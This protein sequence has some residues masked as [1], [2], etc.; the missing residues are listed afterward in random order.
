MTGGSA[1]IDAS[2][3]HAL[4]FTGKA[5]VTIPAGSSIISNAFNLSTAVGQ[6][7]TVSLY[8]AKGQTGNNTTAQDKSHASTSLGPGDQTSEA[9]IRNGNS[10]PHW[11]Y[12]TEIQGQE[13][14]SA[15]S[16]ICVGDGI[17]DGTGSDMNGNNRWTDDLFRRMQ[18][19]LATK[20]VVVLNAGIGDN[21]LVTQAALLGLCP[22]TD[23]QHTCVEICLVLRQHATT[24]C[25][26]LN[27]HKYTS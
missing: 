2:S 1:D 7:L 14:S 19:N 13:P 22:L 4:T 12:V 3:V 10:A 6:E 11:Y 5:A 8:L 24:Q 23:V 18:N 27:P 9:T 25:C 15:S 26:I 16:L 20:D 21:H 17:T